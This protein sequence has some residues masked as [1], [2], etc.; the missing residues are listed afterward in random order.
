V[1]VSGQKG[2]QMFLFLSL[3]PS[4]KERK[5][6]YKTVYYLWAFLSVHDIHESWHERYA[7]T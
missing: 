6:T 7:I 2:E 1:G 5:H 3:Y 4:L